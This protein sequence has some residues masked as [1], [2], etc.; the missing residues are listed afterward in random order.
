MTNN[1]TLLAA[2]RQSI[3][4]TV[5]GDISPTLD[6]AQPCCRFPIRSLLRKPCAIQDTHC[7]GDAPRA[8]SQMLDHRQSLD[9]NSVSRLV[10]GFQK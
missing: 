3:R 2:G 7:L 9:I 5:W 6:C 10:P 4:A 1:L 8:Q